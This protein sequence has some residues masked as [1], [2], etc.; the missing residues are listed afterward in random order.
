MVGLV[1]DITFNCI[2]IVFYYGNALQYYICRTAVAYAWKI[3][4]GIQNAEN[5]FNFMPFCG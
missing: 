1:E 3:C 4:T 5:I 2:A